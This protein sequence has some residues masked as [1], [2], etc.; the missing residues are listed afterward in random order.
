MSVTDDDRPVE[1]SASLPVPH[2]TAQPDIPVEAAAAGR[3][4]LLLAVVAAAVLAAAI[5]FVAGSRLQSSSDARASAEAPEPA[6]ITVPIERRE[7]ASTVVVRGD[8]RFEE[9]ADLAVAGGF[10]AEVNPVVTRVGP[11]IGDVIGEGALVV[12]VGGRPVFLL[13]GDL[14]TFRDLRP[15]QTGDDVVQLQE[16]LRRLG[17]LSGA[18]DGTYGPSTEEAVTALYTAAGYVAPG[19]TEEE[20]T[21]L[22]AARDSVDDARSSLRSAEASRSDLGG[23]VSESTRLVLDA[24]VARAE[25]E[26]ERV[27][28]ER[29]AALAE[30]RQARAD[31]ET[32]RDAGKVRVSEAE[33]ALAAAQADLAAAA[34][35]SQDEAT[36]TQAVADAE[37]EL[38]NV[39]SALDGLEQALIDADRALQAAVDE[40]APALREAET[41]L[42][43]ARANRSEALAPID[44]S[45]ADQAITD[46]RAAVERAEEDLAD[47]EAATGTTMPQTELIFLAALPRRVENVL[48]ERGD[49]VQGPVMNVSGVDLIIDS[50]VAAADRPLLEEGL[51]VVLDEP[52]L[53]IEVAGEIVFLATSPGTGGVGENRYQMQVRATETLPPEAQGVNLRIQIPVSSTGGE[54]LA[55]PLAALSSSADGTARVEVEDADGT[56]RFV[57]VQVGLAAGGFAE[58]T[59][60]SG[61]LSAGDRV[62]VG[63][64][65]VDTSGDDADGEDEPEEPEEPAEDEPEEDS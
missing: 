4:R 62:V 43:I 20:E 32:A 57:D 5:G 49:A 10:G 59:P 33:A 18:P 45:S 3:R 65:G 27:Q 50:G 17:H 60:L 34:P 31:A 64:E 11:V 16:A 39:R 6:L 58:I 29:D 52:G 28:A 13:E 30:P 38:A 37:T 42:A 19:L 35:G 12:E 1:S 48:V 53:G 46:A 8:V 7:I 56:T 22:R 54:V 15:G 40:L 51:T 47:L 26:L 44:T 23:N 25:D 21:Q 14:P 63:A 36:A 2:Q 55:V 9:S 61:S 24:E 41:A